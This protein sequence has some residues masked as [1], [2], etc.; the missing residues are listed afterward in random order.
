MV[1]AAEL[2]VID[3]RLAEA[4]NTRFELDVDRKAKPKFLKFRKER[5]SRDYGIML[6]VNTK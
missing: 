4:D 6:A 5:L 1:L 3:M 2:D